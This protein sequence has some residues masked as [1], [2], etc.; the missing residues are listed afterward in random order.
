[1][2]RLLELAGHEVQTADRLDSALQTARTFHPEVVLC[3]VGLGGNMEGLA[4]AT[5][6]RAD[7]QFGSPYL[8]AVTG[9]GQ[10]E[11]RDRTMAAGF[12]LHI[13]KPADPNDLRRI[14]AELPDRSRG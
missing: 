10:T 7:S 13:T 3:D 1:M 8:I 14:L 2:R 11:D 4:V 9:Y 12:D 6:L 5:E